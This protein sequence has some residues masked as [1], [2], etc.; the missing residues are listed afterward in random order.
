VFAITAPAI[1][2]GTNGFAGS[3]S[4]LASVTVTTAMT[5]KRITNAV[6]FPVI[7]AEILPLV[8]RFCFA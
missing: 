3:G 1:R 2:T 5:L 6:N 7:F 4:G 8:R